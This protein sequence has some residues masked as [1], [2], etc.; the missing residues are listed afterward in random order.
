MSELSKIHLN[1]RTTQKDKLKAIC[2][3]KGIPMT[4]IVNMLINDFIKKE[5][6]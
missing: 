2:K 4:S 3:R 5:S 6:K 1:I